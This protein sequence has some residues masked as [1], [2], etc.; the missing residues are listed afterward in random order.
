[1]AEEVNLESKIVLNLINI[2][3]PNKYIVMDSKRRNFGN[4]KNGLSHGEVSIEEMIIPF[5]EIG[6][7]K[8]GDLIDL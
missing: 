1:M 4:R 5:I 3:G 8:W 2:M 6:G 7:D